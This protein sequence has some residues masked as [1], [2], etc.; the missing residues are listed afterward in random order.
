VATEARLEGEAGTAMQLASGRLQAAVR[1]NWIQPPTSTLGLSALINVHVRPTGEVISAR[2]IRSSGNA[3]FDRSAE[4]AVLKASPLPIPTNPR[5][6]KY[7]K[8]FNF[9]FK[10]NG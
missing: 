9:E 8:N 10:P 2:V 7:L 6:Y 4:I 5:Y 1:S 3:L